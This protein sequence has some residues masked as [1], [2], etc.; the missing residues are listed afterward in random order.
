MFFVKGSKY[1]LDIYEVSNVSYTLAMG[2]HK[3]ALHPPKIIIIN[4]S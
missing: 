1:F 2:L 3:L 4:I